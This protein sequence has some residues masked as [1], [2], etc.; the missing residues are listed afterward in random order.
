[1]PSV[2]DYGVVF[3]VAAA[4]MFV[5]TGLMRWIAPRIGAIVQPDDRRVHQR[6]TPTLGGVAMFLGLV[7]GGGTAWRVDVFDSQLAPGAQ[8][9]G[10]LLAALVTPLVGP[11]DAIPANS[12]P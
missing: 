2:R 10:M 12:P 5:V 1:M 11:V 8:S 9:Y 3:G 7:A 6:P 4:V